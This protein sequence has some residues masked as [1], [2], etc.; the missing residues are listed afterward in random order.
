MSDFDVLVAG[1]GLAAARAVKSYRE[2]G[3]GWR[4]ALVGQ[5]STLPCH[6]PA[7]SKRYLGGETR[8]DSFRGARRF[9]SWPCARQPRAGALARSS[10]DLASTR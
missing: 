3:G 6:R 8:P 5:E 9:T 10:S 7:L 1:G 2:A 4:V